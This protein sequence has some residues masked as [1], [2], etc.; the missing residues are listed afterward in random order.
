MAGPCPDLYKLLFPFV[1]LSIT[2]TIFQNNEYKELHKTVFENLL[3]ESLSYIHVL[4]SFTELDIIR[5]MAR[6]QPHFPVLMSSNSSSTTSV[7]PEQQPQLPSY[8]DL[9]SC[10]WHMIASSSSMWQDRKH[11]LTIN[12][13]TPADGNDEFHDETTWYE[14]NSNKQTSTKGICSPL[15]TEPGFVYNWRGAGWLRWVTTKW[16]ILGLGVWSSNF[17]DGAEVMEEVNEDGV[18]VLVTLVSKTMF[19][20]QAI[21]IFLQDRLAAVNEE[22]VIKGILEALKSLGGQSLCNE[23]DKMVAIPRN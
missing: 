7:E 22:R 10:T 14:D 20:P 13:S 6:F 3:L 12:Y 4:L 9:T 1:M 18:V 23:V 15:G 21:S 16:E 17:H 2:A 11:S 8:R 5:M 19:S